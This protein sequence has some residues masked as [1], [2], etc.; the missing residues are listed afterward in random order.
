MQELAYKS[1]GWWEPQ[2]EGA[3]LAVETQDMSSLLRALRRPIYAVRQESGATA[4][5]SGGRIVLSEADANG[6]LPLVAWAPALSAGQ[7]GDGEFRQRYGLKYAC[8]SGSMANAI[9]SEALVE[10][11]VEH[12]MLGFFGAAGLSPQRVEEAIHSLRSKLGQR[13]HGFNLINSPNDPALE[14]AIVGLYLANGVRLIEASAYLSLTLPLLKFRYSGIHRGAD[15]TIVV[16]NSVMGKVSRLETAR[17]FLSLPPR[18]MLR[19]LVA[20]GVLSPEQADLAAQIPVCSELTAEADSG[21]HTDNRAAISLWP[22]ILELRDEMEAQHGYRIPIGAAGGIATPLS[23]SV[24]F[25]MGA[26]YVVT[27]SINQACRES[28]T[29]DYVRETLAKASQTDVTMAPAADMFE[30]G[31]NVQVLKWGT[32]FPVKARKLYGWYRQYDSLEQLPD[33]VRTQLERDYLRCT[34]EE[35]WQSTR[36]FFQK[37]DP[38]QITRAE[39]DPKYLMALIFRSYLGQASR[40]ANSGDATR[41]ADYQIWCGPSM[42]AFNEWTKGTFLAQASARKAGLVALNLLAGACIATRLNMLRLQGVALP[43][44]LE[45]IAPLNEEQLSELLN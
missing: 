6:A 41:R 20:Q 40:W 16:P 25:A 14:N 42:G 10:A 37:R 36:A 18:D 24:A 39:R 3:I 17:K 7:L 13:A 35:S 9:A 28:G 34:L 4:L 38:R 12:G 23:V 19:E 21:G 31:V 32:L 29:C 43:S 15:G 22:S 33:E 45:R 30:M 2:A 26:S 27:G 5:C 8:V 1:L 11:M 44:A